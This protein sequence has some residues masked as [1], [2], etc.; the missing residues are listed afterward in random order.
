MDEVGVL[1]SLEDSRTGAHRGAD[2]LLRFAALDRG[3]AVD[4]PV[5]G[6]DL[7]DAGRFGLGDE[8]GLREVQPLELIDLERT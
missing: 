3:D 2:E 7:A 8:V 1:R 4:R 6:G 5:E